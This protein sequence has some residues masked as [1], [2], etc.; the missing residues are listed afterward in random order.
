MDYFNNRTIRIISSHNKSEYI[1]PV[2]KSAFQLKH[3]T[4][5]HPHT[6]ELGTFTGTIERK[7]DPIAT[8]KQKC[9]W[10][11]TSDFNGLIL[12]SEGSF[13]PS[14][15]SPFIHINEEHLLL[16]DCKNGFEIRGI[17]RSIETNF[18]TKT[19]FSFSELIRFSTKA[20]FP[21]HKIILKP[22]KGPLIYIDQN[23]EQLAQIC[24][25]E[26]LFENG[27]EV[28]TDMRAMNNPSRQKII[29]QAAHDLVKNMQNLCPEC[30]SPGFS[31][32]QS[33]LGLPCKYCNLPTKSIKAFTYL[34]DECGFK[35]DFPV[36]QLFQEA[37]Y[38]DYCNP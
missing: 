18:S 22:T 30:Q 15:A 20:Q 10:G 13:G 26:A 27:L 5:T 38:C 8:A 36:E 6:D 14:I 29:E 35:K 33:I 21:S 32:H 16:I 25:N 11:K 9:L 23:E 34:C 17:A 28:M 31:K 12:A 7:L 2:L 24:C 19:V 3:E 1:L 37:A 4:I